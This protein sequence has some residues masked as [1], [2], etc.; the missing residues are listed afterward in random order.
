MT[1]A[2]EATDA[3]QVSEASLEAPANRANAVIETPKGP[4][5]V[6]VVMDSSGSM[7]GQIDGRSKRDIA[8]EAVRAMVESNPELGLAGL[9]A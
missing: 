2:L 9:I 6:M 1:T 5:K 3:P 8:R 7:W 4:M